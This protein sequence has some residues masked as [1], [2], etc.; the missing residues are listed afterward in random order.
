[1]GTVDIVAGLTILF[2]GM[3]GFF[4]MFRRVHGVL[5]GALVACVLLGIA[6]LI[7]LTGPW[8]ETTADIVK[9]ST[10]LSFLAEKLERLTTALLLS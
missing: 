2:F 4:G 1:M 10:V 3:L 9:N 7:L 8:A 6:G 5:S